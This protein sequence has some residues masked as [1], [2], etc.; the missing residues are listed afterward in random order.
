MARRCCSCRCRWPGWLRE[1]EARTCTITAIVSFTF[2]VASFAVFS[3][4][5]LQFLQAR[6]T[7]ATCF[8]SRAEDVFGMSNCT[9]TSCSQ[10][11]TAELYTCKHLYVTY[12]PES[13]ETTHELNEKL[14][15][16]IDSENETDIPL[17]VNIRAC[18]YEPEVKC[19]DFINIYSEIS[20][21]FNC[22]IGYDHNGMNFAVPTDLEAQ[23]VEPEFQAEYL[24]YT[25]VP[26]VL[27][28][29]SLI[30]IKIRKLY[31]M[32]RK[33]EEKIKSSKRKK[34]TF[35]EK[36]LEEKSK[37]KKAKEKSEEILYQQK[38][39]Q[40]QQQQQLTDTNSL[41]EVLISKKNQLDIPLIRVEKRFSYDSS[42]LGSFNISQISSKP[43]DSHSLLS[44]ISLPPSQFHSS[45]EHLIDKDKENFF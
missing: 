37:K 12:F 43:P 41:N 25:I 15:Y 32:R 21:R 1:L 23:F 2:A 24:I 9:W 30:W 28:I 38:Q 27:C 35:Y 40:Q 22:Q 17:L 29:T 10:S 16:F 18:G 26:L 33:K 6:L 34:Q 11:C 4:S 45:K 5:A 39:Q 8:V 31:R 20:L 19:S 7:S 13:N 42:S 14:D 44:V 3:D 36:K